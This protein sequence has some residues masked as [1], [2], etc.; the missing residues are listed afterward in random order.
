MAKNDNMLSILWML[1]GGAKVTAKQIADKLEINIRTVYRYIDSLC[2]SGVPV[3]S[4]SG[5]NGGYSLLNSFIEVPLI[6]D[7]EEQK[8]LLHA[9]IFAR[10]AGYPSKGALNSASQKLRL[11]LNQN[12]KSI[13]DHHMVGFE[14]IN[15][16]VCTEV[17]SVIEEIEQAVAEESSVEID[18]RSKR[19][20]QIA[21][22][23][24]DPYGIIYWNNKWYTVG[25]CH[26][27]KEIRSFRIERIAKINQTDIKFK[28]PSDFSASTYFLQSILQSSQSSKAAVEVVIEGSAEAL[29]DLCIH[30]FLS[31]CLK[32][33]TQN[34]AV[35]LI[36]ENVI[37][38]YVPYFLFSYGKSIKVI[39]PEKLKKKLVSVMLELIEYYKT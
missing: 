13:I 6:F 25:Y 36:D 18:Y 38:I 2:A 22:R 7:L 9:V 15:R 37:Y 12:Q 10:K 24:I 14:V 21:T 4:D 31:R 3:V 20:E 29:D 23:I 30:W 34:K 33:R 16:E 35:F 39:E 8:S 28:R 1:S 5:R 32:E 19:D 27:R 26:L 11:H 17:K